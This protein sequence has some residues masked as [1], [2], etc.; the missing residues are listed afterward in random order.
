[1]HGSKF[2]QIHSHLCNIHYFSVTYSTPIA[3]CEISCT[4]NEHRLTD[5]AVLQS[6]EHD[7]NY[8]T[9][10][11]DVTISCCKNF[12]IL[13]AM[14]TLLCVYYV[15][16]SYNEDNSS[17]SSSG[18]VIGSVVAGVFI[19]VIIV[20]LVVCRLII[21][22]SYIRRNQNRTVIVAQ[23]QTPRI[24][25][26]RVTRTVSSHPPPPPAYTPSAPNDGY[27]PVPPRGYQPVPTTDYAPANTAARHDNIPSDP[28]PEYTP[29]VSSQAALPVSEDSTQ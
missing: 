1:M 5:C 4:G 28:P 26:A 21:R 16:H 3:V 25:I 7:Y 23:R 2:C 14:C 9:H 27:A 18:A 20:F 22:Y 12:L 6:C 10:D 8:C 24:M 29:A 15:D 17:S 11:L 13:L 19:V